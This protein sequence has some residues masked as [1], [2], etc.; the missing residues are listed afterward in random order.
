MGVQQGKVELTLGREVLVQHGLAHMG[1]FGDLIHGGAVVTV[2]DKD[3]LGRREELRPALIPGKPG[4][5]L[6]RSALRYGRFPARRP[7]SLCFMRHS[8]P[9]FPL[10][11]LTQYCA[12]I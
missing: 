10:P 5:P 3:L 1:R 12:V 9:Y 4:G 11:L 8:F 7:V 6:A 2:G